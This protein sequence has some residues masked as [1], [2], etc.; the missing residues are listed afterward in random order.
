[1]SETPVCRR[2]GSELPKGSLVQH[3]Y[4]KVKRILK[5]IFAWIFHAKIGFFAFTLKKE[6]MINMFNPFKKEKGI[7]EEMSLF[8]KQEKDRRSKAEAFVE[9]MVE[10][11][12]YAMEEVWGLSDSQLI[13]GDTVQFKADGT[14]SSFFVMADKDTKLDILNL[15]GQAFWQSVQEV[16]NFSREM[17]EDVKRREVARDQ[18]LAGMGELTQELK[19]SSISGSARKKNPFIPLEPSFLK[20]N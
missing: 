8:V 11:V 20:N 19:E 12:P 6:R 1:M 5:P 7:Q 13:I 10:V 9:M 2:Q 17:L 4:F 14:S 18:L 15:R 16:M 3:F